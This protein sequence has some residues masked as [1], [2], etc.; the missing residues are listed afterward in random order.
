MSPHVGIRFVEQSPC[1]WSLSP[2]SLTS[3]LG[4][5]VLGL[6][7]TT[8]GRFSLLCHLTGQH[9]TSLTANLRRGRDVKGLLI[10]DHADIFLDAYHE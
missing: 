2:E 10:L 9:A 7:Q 8:A 1:V 6:L 3:A 5:A 4:P